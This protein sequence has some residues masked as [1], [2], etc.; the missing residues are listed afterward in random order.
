M[1]IT[2]SVA[3]LDKI[4]PEVSG[5]KLFKLYYFVEECLQT[6]HKTILTF[7][8]AYSNH[9][10]AT[11]FLCRETNL[12][13]I[14]IVRGEQS[15]YLSH[16]LTQ[17]RE[18]G[19]E[20]HFVSRSEYK[21]FK[22]INEENIIKSYGECITIPEGGYSTT[23]AKGASMIT[24]GIAEKNFT[25]ICTAVGTATTLAGLLNGKKPAQKII[26]V[27]VLKNMTDIYERLDHLLP[28][29][30]KEYPE[31]FND[32]HFGGYAKYTDELLLFMNGFFATHNIP[33]DFLYTGKLMFAI[34][35]KIKNGYFEKGS[36]IICLHTGGLQGNL[37]LQKGKLI[38]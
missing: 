17:C 20:L 26:G 11:A 2:L 37:S 12:K 35:D 33:T 34:I 28:A 14:G 3:R 27:P 6:S 32:Y 36:R 10:A 1:E 29:D 8:G 5:N 25:H 22:E 15:K 16:T 21:Q 23:G 13:C 19:M 30:Q 4:H 24:D 7:G 9:L 31:I 18:N 38:F